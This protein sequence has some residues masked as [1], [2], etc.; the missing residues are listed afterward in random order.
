VKLTALKL[1]FCLSMLV[2][3]VVFG[4]MVVTATVHPSVV[5]TS[6][7]PVLTAM[8]VRLPEET[9]VSSV[10]QETLVSAPVSLHD[11]QP[12]ESK[13]AEIPVLAEPVPTTVSPFSP[14]I[15]IAS[16]AQSSLAFIGTEPMSQLGSS[17]GNGP[18]KSS[19]NAATVTGPPQVRAQPNYLKTP[20][21]DYPPLA[22]RRR[23]EGLVLLIVEV[24][25]AGKATSVRIKESSGFPALDAAALQAVREWEFD[26]ARI[27]SRAFASEIE[28]PVRFKLSP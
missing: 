21:P 15:E 9:K 5:R 26:P 17:V 10:S 6:E 1:A 16:V 23:Q 24:T 22:R 25:A 20:A 13:N 3:A 12:V 8:V 18:A 28:V 7:D 4:L 11:P 27:G 2:H 19:N 14:T